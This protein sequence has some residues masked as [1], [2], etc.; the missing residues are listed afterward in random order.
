MYRMNAAILSCCESFLCLATE[1][2]SR[3]VVETRAYEMRLPCREI[4]SIRYIESDLH[5]RL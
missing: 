3:V 2:I 5:M 1:D 4:P